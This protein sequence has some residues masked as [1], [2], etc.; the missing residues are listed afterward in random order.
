MANNNQFAEYE[1]RSAVPARPRVAR[2]DVFVAGPKPPAAQTGAHAQPQP[3]ASTSGWTAE[4]Q[5]AALVCAGPND[6]SA[7]KRGYE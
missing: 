3:H 5:G 1:I 7:L 6:A 4:G 2:D